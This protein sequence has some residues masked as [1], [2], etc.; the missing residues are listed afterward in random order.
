MD[1]SRDLVDH[2]KLDAKYVR[3]DQVT[4][5]THCEADTSQISKK[6]KFV[7]RWTRKRQLG[8]RSFWRC[9]PRG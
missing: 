7:K 6:V 5:Q 3:N 1:P 9:V 4:R 8:K 2:F